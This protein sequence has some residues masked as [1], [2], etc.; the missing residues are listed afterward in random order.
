MLAGCLCCDN[1]RITLGNVCCL[2][3]H[4]ACWCSVCVS[5]LDVLDVFLLTVAARTDGGRRQRLKI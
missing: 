4:S 1:A 2:F 3:V 5:V